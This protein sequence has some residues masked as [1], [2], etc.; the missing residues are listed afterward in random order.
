MVL[1][2]VE[3]N[4][5][6]VRKAAIDSLDKQKCN[7]IV[8]QSPV[9]VAKRKNKNTVCIPRVLDYTTHSTAIETN[10]NFYDNITV[11]TENAEIENNLQIDVIPND[12]LEPL[13]ALQKGQTQSGTRGRKRRISETPRCKVN[14]ENV[15][16]NSVQCLTP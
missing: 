11:V 12:R 6:T 16:K 13:K 2:D 7:K 5:M 15:Y 8:I 10:Q 3:T 14:M 1:T 9:Q 4:E